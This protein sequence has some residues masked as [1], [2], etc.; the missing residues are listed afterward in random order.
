M[1]EFLYK[2]RDWENPYH[3]RMISEQEI[4]F[5]TP[6]EF[7]DPFDCKII[8]RYDKL[9]K[10]ERYQK[11]FNIIKTDHP[12]WSRKKIELFAKRNYQRNKLDKDYLKK[13]GD[14]N[15][16]VVLNQI[17]IFSTTL[18]KNNILL[19]SHYANSHKGFC[20][21]FNKNLLIDN[22]RDSWNRIKLPPTYRSVNYEANYPEIIPNS[23]INDKNF[24]E[25]PMFVKF[26]DWEH[27][28]EYRI[29][30]LSTGSVKFKVKKETISEINLGC[31]MESNHK[32]SIIEE[33]RRNL[34]KVKIY[35]AQKKY[36]DFALDFEP[37][38][39]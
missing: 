2:F 22:I 18:I 12:D 39:V 34:P 31:E 25:N 10:T 5:A 15:I 17:G 38:I 27:E 29:I 26:K 11:H 14:T 7:N 3:Q 32:I 16:R 13:F 23:K 35:Q 20:V 37:I 8:P 6:L 4:Y 28:K 1:S 33:V 9:S 30:L 36:M 24:V 21:G 19:W